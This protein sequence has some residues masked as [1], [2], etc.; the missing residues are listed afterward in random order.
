L[1][2]TLSSLNP[3][4][5]LLDRRKQVIKQ[6]ITSLAIVSRALLVRLECSFKNVVRLACRPL[7]PCVEPHHAVHP[8]ETWKHIA[9][10]DRFEQTS[11][12]FHHREE[13]SGIHASKLVP[14]HRPRD[15]SVG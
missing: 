13:T 9:H 8:L 12:L 15:D 6:V 7:Y 11:Y 5:T 10:H 3:L 1:T 4:S 2:S 14:E